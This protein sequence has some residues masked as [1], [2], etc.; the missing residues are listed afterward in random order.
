MHVASPS[1]LFGL[2]RTQSTAC[3]FCGNARQDNVVSCVD[4]ARFVTRFQLLA[5][6][7]HSGELLAFLPWFLFVPRDLGRAVIVWIVDQCGLFL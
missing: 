6:V 1:Q 4:R 2:T 3:Q 5:S 7:G